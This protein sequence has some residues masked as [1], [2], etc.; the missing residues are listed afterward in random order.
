MIGIFDSGIGGL[1][2]YSALK[3]L[4]PRVSCFYFADHR[5]FPYGEKTKNQIIDYT[6]Q[7]SDFLVKQGSE[8]IV[9]AC[10]TATI[11]SIQHLR[12]SFQVPFVGTVPA[13]K[14]ACLQ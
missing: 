2:I 1:S 7:I 3:Q 8:L 12:K 10:N 6:V 9:V 14:P 4:M 13:I 11:T 5:H